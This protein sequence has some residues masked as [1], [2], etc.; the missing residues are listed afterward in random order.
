MSVSVRPIDRMRSF[1]WYAPEL[2]DPPSQTRSEFAAAVVGRD[3][4]LVEQRVELRAR[5]GIPRYSERTVAAI[6]SFTVDA[7][8]K[9]AFAFHAAPQPPVR[10][11]T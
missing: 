9:R 6:A 10:L 11:W 7:A 3:D 1:T 8:G 2:V 5:G 4:H